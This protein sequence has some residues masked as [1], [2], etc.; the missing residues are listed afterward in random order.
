MGKEECEGEVLRSWGAKRDPLAGNLDP[1][2]IR[3]RLGNVYPFVLGTSWGIL[4]NFEVLFG[5]S[6]VVLGVVEVVLGRSRGVLGDLRVLS[7]RSCAGLDDAK[8]ANK[9]K[10]K[11]TNKYIHGKKQKRS[12]NDAWEADP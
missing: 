4:G 11:T 12:K 8:K 1:G 9:K 3:G 6:W 10:N 5:K 7:G 2:V